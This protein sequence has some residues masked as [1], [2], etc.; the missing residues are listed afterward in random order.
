MAILLVVL[1]AV[2]TS[3]ILVLVRRW[4]GLERLN[5]NNEVAGF[6]FAVV[7][8]IYAVMLAF[9]VIIVWE[10][11]AEAEMAVIQEA[12][13]AATLRR[14]AAG[15]GTDAVQMRRAL[16]N[17]LSTAIERDWPRMALEQESPEVT[18]AL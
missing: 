1:P 4:V 3:W 13:A 7:G 12:G 11:Y 8:V 6:K 18:A 10:R 14:L 17:Y 5:I 16:R 2:A 15:S 9:A